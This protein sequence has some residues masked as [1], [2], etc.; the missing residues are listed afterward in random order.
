MA[1]IST[2]HGCHWLQRIRA[3]VRK[4]R[5]SFTAQ[6]VEMWKGHTFSSA[7]CW[8][9]TTVRRKKKQRKKKKSRCLYFNRLVHSLIL[10]WQD[11]VLLGTQLLG[12]WKQGWTAPSSSPCRV[13]LPCPNSPELSTQQLLSVEELQMPEIYRMLWFGS[14]TVQWVLRKFMRNSYDEKKDVWIW[15]ISLH[16]NKL[17]FSTHFLYTL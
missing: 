7:C 16:Q 11:P 14:F 12:S 5:T 13:T 4:A 15:S 9:T 10:L 6:C 8:V 17:K 2:S 3:N 1:A